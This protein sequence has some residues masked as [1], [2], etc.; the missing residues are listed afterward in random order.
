MY[1][2]VNRR[3]EQSGDHE[4]ERLMLSMDKMFA[5]ERGSSLWYLFQMWQEYR[6]VADKIPTIDQFSYKDKLP[7]DIR[8]NISWVSLD[9]ENPLYFVC[10]DHNPKSSFTNHSGLRIGDHPVPMNARACAT[11]YLHCATIRRPI[12]FEIKQTIG[13]K[14]RHFMRL[15]VPIIDGTKEVTRLIYAVRLISGQSSVK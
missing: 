3:H 10:H 5:R 1:G 4:Q 9:V 15:M 6:L 11:E 7:A 12:Y 14:S 2:V 8:E 13:A